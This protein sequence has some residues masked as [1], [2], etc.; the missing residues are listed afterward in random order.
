MRCLRAKRACSGYDDSTVSL[1]RRY[2]V[3][4]AN[5][6]APF[7]STAR[8][9]TIPIRI[10]IP[11]TD[12][13]PQD[14]RPTE[15]TQAESNAL[16]L[17]AFFYDFCIISSNE[18]LSKGFLSSL[19]KKIH[20][21]GPKSDLAKACQAVGFASHGKPLRRPR[22]VHIAETFYHELLGSLAS[23]IE[24]PALARSDESKILAMLLGLYEV[25]SIEYPSWLD[26]GT[27]LTR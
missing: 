7:L 2:D 24:N 19:E 27:N 5:Q 23:T 15:F 14:A 4:D 13:L 11:G 6:S 21:L 18:N 20:S 3:R 25:P 8:K 10:P 22:F 26:H 1:F 16:A 17:R 12:V 9:C